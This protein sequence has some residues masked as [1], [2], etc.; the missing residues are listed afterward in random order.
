MEW[1]VSV[2]GILRVCC[3]V[4]VST[5]QYVRCRTVDAHALGSPAW[6][7]RSEAILDREA[8]RVVAPKSTCSMAQKPFGIADLVQTWLKMDR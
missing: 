6:L 1:F 7:G 4:H 2:L 8:V 5:V 3:A